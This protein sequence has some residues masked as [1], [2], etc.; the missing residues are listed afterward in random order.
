MGAITVNVLVSNRRKKLICIACMSM[1]FTYQFVSY[2][3]NVSLTR[4]LEEIGSLSYYSAIATAHTLGMMISAPVAGRL[5]D[6]LGRK[7][8]TVCSLGLFLAS[9][10]FASL[11]IHP[12]AYLLFRAV[13]SACAGF[14]MGMMI[15]LLSDVTEKSERPP[16]LGLLSSSAATGMLLGPLVGGLLSDM[17]LYRLSHL[18]G[19][20]TGVFSMVVLV[21]FYPNKKN[22]NLDANTKFDFKGLLLLFVSACSIVGWLNFSGKAFERF[23]L[24]GISL[25]ALGACCAI[26]L[27]LVEKRSPNPVLDLTLFRYREFRIASLC[28]VLYAVYIG[29][30]ANYIPLYGQKVL[31]ISATITST[32]AI[33][34]T[35]TSIV[36]SSFIGVLIRRS[37]KNFKPAYI[38]CGLCGAVPLLV[39][40]TLLSRSGNTILVYAFM[41]FG[42]IGYA[43]DQVISSA[44]MQTTMPT[45]K[46]GFAQGFMVF[47]SSSGMTMANAIAGT[48]VNMGQSLQTSIPIVFLVSAAAVS[49]IFFMGVFVIKRAKNEV[50]GQVVSA[51][52]RP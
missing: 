39:W 25:L 10:G 23:S 35:I 5:S 41:V 49:V 6:T 17:G 47:C 11:A 46:L 29:V 15:A 52:D 7:W 30:A 31:G 32:L 50:A 37:Q 12:M 8:L 38:V 2:A 21:L 36:L 4:L 34:Q 33:P 44:Y 20:P 48:I 22:P 9:M 14:F 1:Y 19:I 27:V 13:C 24:T 3:C 43:L 42:G 26:L 16:W 51:S 18:V 40:S 28:H 45:E